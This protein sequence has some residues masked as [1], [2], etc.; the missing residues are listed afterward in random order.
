MIRSD[1]ELRSAKAELKKKRSDLRA[2]REA[3][4]QKGANAD[5]LGVALKPQEDAVDALVREIKVYESS[6][7][8]SFGELRN[9]SDFGRLLVSIRLASGLSQLELAK[10]LEVDPS[11]VSRDERT[12]YR[13][14]TIERANKI[15]EA[16]GA[17][18]R[19]RLTEARGAGPA[20]NKGVERKRGVGA[21]G[22]HEGGRQA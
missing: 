12:E 17:D 2:Q 19:S 13:G 8:G 18:L 10:R 21:R 22:G 15:L 3:L 16:M 7:S 14:V 4:K 5:V 20:R 6:R 1:S 11:Q 9:L